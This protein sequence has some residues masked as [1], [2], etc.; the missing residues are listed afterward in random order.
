MQSKVSMWLSR[1]Q[2]AGKINDLMIANKSFEM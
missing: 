2:N 1:N